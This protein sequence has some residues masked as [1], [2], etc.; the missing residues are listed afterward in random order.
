MVKSLLAPK[1]PTEVEFKEIVKQMT[2]HYHPTPAA[3][4]QRF[5]F[6][7][8]SR[9]PGESVATYVSELKK[10]SEYCEFGTSLDEML[11]DRL[12]CGIGDERWQRRL[13]SEPK[14]D[15]EKA[16]QLAQALE[17]AERNVKDLQ[18]P[19]RQDKL[20][21]LQSQ[22]ARATRH[23][24]SQCYRCGADH[25]PADCRFKDAECHYCHKKGHIAKVCRSKARDRTRRPPRRNPPRKGTH[26]VTEE[27]EAPEYTLYHIPSTSSRPLLVIVTLD[28]AETQMEVDT[29]ATLSIISM[30]TYKQLWSR[31][32]A[33]RLRASNATLKTYTGERID[34]EGTISVNVAYEKQKARLNLLVV[35]G[36]G[37]SLLGRDWLQ[38]LKL[39]WSQLH[40]VPSPSSN[41]WEEVLRRHADVFEEKLGLLQGTTAKIHIDP[42][43]QP[44]FC[45][46][47]PVPYALR[48]KV[49]HEL[50]RLE[51]DGVIEPVQ[52]SDWAAP[53]VPVVKKD[54]S[55]R[56]CGD[57]KLTVNQAA[58]TDT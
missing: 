22:A 50:D 20:H 19:E 52:F 34:V 44:K 6:H 12:V 27:G 31:Q 14:L 10:L 7:S 33:P 23:E 58:K 37:P 13:L 5:Q 21:H 45:R 24:P 36:E 38:H 29:G 16:F 2:A 26:H 47:R 54:G 4:V 3:T 8:R 49:E 32:Q 43:V 28:N 40:Y 57:Y 1:K 51:K 35:T 48:V 30:T 55:V 17:A 9:K 46:A 53:I 15:Y 42:Q 39:N 25:Q 18:S 11:R 56:I 41:R